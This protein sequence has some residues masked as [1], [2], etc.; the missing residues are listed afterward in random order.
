ME[1]LSQMSGMTPSPS[2]QF[3]SASLPPEVLQAAYAAMR[4]TF[5]ANL[6]RIR[7]ARGLKCYGAALELG[8]SASTWGRW[9]A[10]RRFPTPLLLAGIATILQTSIADFFAPLPSSQ[11]EDE[12]T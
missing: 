5:A 4:R 11:N 2:G 1:G 10:A 9:E 3:R 6:R 8:V 12:N 7:K